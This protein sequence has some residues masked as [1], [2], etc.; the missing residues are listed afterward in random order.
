MV[1]ITLFVLAMQ[2][3]N[4]P[5]RWGANGPFAFDCSGLVLKVLNDAGTLLPDM[6]AQ[7]IYDWAT[8]EGFES[9]EPGENCLL[10]FGNSLDKITHTAIASSDGVF[11]I[12]AGGAG[13]ESETMS[14]DDLARKDARV[15]IKKINRRKD[16]LTAI[17]VRF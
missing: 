2:Y 16:L 10:F 9:C 3:A 11:M 17:K 13:R 4:T 12:E 14:L 5:Y 8:K 1:K 15:R 6:T 7:E